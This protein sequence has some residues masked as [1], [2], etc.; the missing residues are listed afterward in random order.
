V[1]Q[2]APEK[3]S[4]HEALAQPRPGRL[5]AG[6]AFGVTWLAYATYYLGRKGFAVSKARLVTELGVAKSTLATLDTGNAAAYA[7][8]QFINGALGDRFGARRLVAFGMWGAALACAAFG[9]STGAWALFLA[10][11]VNGLLQSTGWPGTTKGMAEWTEPR[12]RGSVMGLWCTCYQV[13][14]LVATAVC[15]YLLVHYGWRSAF[16]IPAIAIGAVGLLVF[17]L[18]RPGPYQATAHKKSTAVIARAALL[19]NPAIWSYGV[20]YFF[21][22]LMRYCFL[23]W[24]P[25]YLHTAVG[26]GEAAAGYLSTSFEIGGIAGSIAIGYISD[27]LPGRSR[28]SVAGVSLVGL[29]AALLLYARLAPTSAIL[30]FAMVAL[31]GAMLFGP[32]S[33]ISCAA[34]QETGSPETAA[35]AT[36][37]VNGIGSLGAV[38]QSWVTVWIQSAWGWSAL[39]YFFVALALLSAASLLPSFKVRPLHLTSE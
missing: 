7:L 38:V 33:L 16:R 5:G 37:F 18:L 3:V 22:K 19:R 39:F 13:G 26:F 28:A 32:D 6:I 30:Q 15:T 36:G 25:Y 1:I 31:I 14:G 20:S 23:L 8:G 21:I 34:A 12:R 17:V 11:T 9:F 24:L 27:R 35:M 10:Y 4:A 29:A 2:P